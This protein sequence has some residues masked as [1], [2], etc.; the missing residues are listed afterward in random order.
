MAEVDDKETVARTVLPFR[1]EYCKTNR[2]KC[3]KC[4]ETMTAGSLKMA[5]VVK[6][7]WSEHGYD[8]FFFHVQCFFRTKRPNSVADI[9]N[10]DTLKYEDQK[11][12]EQAIES[13]GKTVLMGCTP[14]PV[15][16]DAKKNGKARKGGS[17]RAL[18]APSEQLVNY[19]DFRVE[20]AKSSRAKCVLCQ[21]SIKK[22][23][24]RFAKMDYAMDLAPG[25]TGPVPRWYHKDCFA[26][27]L[28]ELDFY[29]SV[30][31][32]ADFNDLEK[33]DQRML[34]KTIKPIE[35]PKLEDVTK[36]LKTENDKDA[37]KEEIALKKQSDR[38]HALREE[39]SRLKIAEVEEMLEFMNQKHS[40]RA[41]NR[42]MDVAA[43]VLLYGPLLPCPKCKKP[44]YM[45]LKNSSYICTYGRDSDKPCD[46]E[47]RDPMRAAPDF[48]DDLVE[49][50]PYF[51][52]EYEFKPGKRIFPKKLIKAVE[53]KEAENNMLVQEDA[54][55]DGLTIG[56]ITW[57]AVKNDKD[58]IR[59][60]VT[61]LGGKL[62]T[63]ID[64]SVFVILSNKNEYEKETPKMEVAK[65]LDIPFARDEFLFEVE[66][67]EDVVPKLTKCLIGTW[68]GD[69]RKRFAKM[70]TSASLSQ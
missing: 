9:E 54:P 29:G 40:Y 14:S 35:A 42:L 55:F 26:K 50:Y 31:K 10:F 58:K 68:E 24:I 8:A 39:V 6:S 13:Q 69:L 7:R 43:D 3:R 45:V 56:V 38:F 19:D 18:V 11:L 60:K 47:T 28:E 44:G 48:P 2:A 20:Y 59:K 23:E 34:K 21:E 66:T 27:S 63:V 62:T 49:K 51:A 30:E 36:K 64:S 57:N 70:L 5:Y 16:D 65:S 4:K 61:L 33:E 67:K 37:I 52:E 46:Y 12:L 53:Q 41:S 15:K 1:A 22:G 25:F 17:K 32:I